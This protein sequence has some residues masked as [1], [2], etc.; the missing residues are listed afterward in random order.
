MS[1]KEI[2]QTVDSEIIFRQ[3][4]LDLQKEYHSKFKAVLPIKKVARLY[5]AEEQFKKVL[6]DKL[7]EGPPVRD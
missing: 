5:Q 6:L 4:E 7:K 1:D 3:K 2:E